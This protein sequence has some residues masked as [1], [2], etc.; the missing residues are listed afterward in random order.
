MKHLVAALLAGALA[1]SGV[2]GAAESY[3]GTVRVTPRPDVGLEVTLDE[4]GNGV[5]DSVFLIL[6]KTPSQVT[7]SSTKALVTID[8]TSFRIIPTDAFPNRALV[9]YLGKGKQGSVPN[10]WRVVADVIG[11]S[12]TTGAVTKTPADVRPPTAEEVAKDEGETKA[13]AESP[14]VQ[15]ALGGAVTNCPGG[16]PGPCI[17]PPPVDDDPTHWGTS[18]CSRSCTMGSC[19]V[20]CNYPTK[21]RCACVGAGWEQLPVCGCTLQ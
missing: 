2:A 6:T 4:D 13:W 9:A 15:E 8:D 3:V 17:P 7:M 12:H 11:I 1:S 19:A 16:P 14:G 10:G 20:I 5:I 18:Q 21:A